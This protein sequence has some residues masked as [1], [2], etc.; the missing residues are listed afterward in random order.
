MKQS[1]L[2]SPGDLIPRGD[3][4]R[5]YIEHLALPE[6]QRN[7]DWHRTERLMR[8]TLNQMQTR[9]P[10]VSDCENLV[11]EIEIGTDQPFTLGP[12]IGLYRNIIWNLG[13]GDPVLGR[14][15][16]SSLAEGQ[17]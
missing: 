12:R 8:A 16:P 3:L 10:I 7:T 11:I 13:D 4:I 5:A 1:L 6:I 15:D 9:I 2:Y 14:Q 17:G